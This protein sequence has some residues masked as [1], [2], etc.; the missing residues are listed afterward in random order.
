VATAGAVMA[1]AGAA[2]ASGM[3]AGA[4]AAPGDPLWRLS[5]RPLVPA[6]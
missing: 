4:A 1:M 6:D 2:A 5:G 3:V